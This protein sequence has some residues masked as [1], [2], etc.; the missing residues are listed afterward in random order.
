MERPLTIALNGLV[1][2][3]VGHAFWRRGFNEP[4]LVTQWAAIVGAELAGRT[5]PVRIAFQRKDRTGGTLHIKVDGAYAIELQHIAP[6]VIERLNAYYGYAALDRLALHQAPVEARPGRR[7]RNAAE[8]DG[9]T[10]NRTKP[11]VPVAASDGIETQGL[12]VPS[13]KAEG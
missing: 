7:T 10:K 9:P 3:M 6:L 1:S 5:L 4:A 2:K 8:D 12:R 13:A 11:A